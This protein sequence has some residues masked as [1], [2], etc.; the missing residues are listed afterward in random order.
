MALIVIAAEGEARGMTTARGHAQP[1]ASDRVVDEDVI[2]FEIVG[3]GWL[4]LS[5]SLSLPES[6]G[7]SAIEVR[8]VSFTRLASI[9]PR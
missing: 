2:R 9:V 5:L 1:A 8:L 3:R 6:F 4:S 7:G